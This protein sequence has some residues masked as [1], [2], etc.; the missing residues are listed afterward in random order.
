MATQCQQLHRSLTVTSQ[1]RIALE[2]QP[3]VEMHVDGSCVFVPDQRFY[4]GRAQC[5]I[6]KK[7][8]SAT[9]ECV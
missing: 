2:L 3:S 4:A 7:G 6:C 5:C 8:T 9:Q 1:H